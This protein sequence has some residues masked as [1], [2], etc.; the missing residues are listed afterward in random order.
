MRYSYS[1]LQQFQD[2]ER[3]YAYR[4]DSRL[5]PVFDGLPKPV[6]GALH[7]GLEHMY[8]GEGQA[9]F[10]HAA[11]EYYWKDIPYE[12]AK[13]PVGELLNEDQERLRKV[14]GGWY[15]VKHLLERYQWRDVP[16]ILHTEATL[17]IDM[18][19]GREYICRI[20]RIMGPNGQVWNHD[21]KSSGFHPAPIIKT[22]RLRHQFAGYSYAVTEWLAGRAIEGPPVPE[23]LKNRVPDG[24][25]VDYLFKPRVTWHKKNKA[26]TGEISVKGESYHREPLHVTSDHIVEFQGW[27]HT[28]AN[29]IE[30]QKHFDLWPKNTN[31]CFRYNSVCSFFEL[32]RNPKRAEQLAA[33]PALFKVKGGKHEYYEA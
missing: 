27:F 28:M 7:K 30:E 22:M 25:I 32:C 12:L 29:R 3:E 17:V 31:H 20:D 23:G 4:Y 6:G 5:E 21:T 33:D 13:L 15:I 2:C 26:F 16:D 8:A 19:H 18:G 24:T 11:K 1:E 9:Q 14:Y 10:I